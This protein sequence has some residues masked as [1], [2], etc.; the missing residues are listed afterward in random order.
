MPTLLHKEHGYE[1]GHGC[2]CGHEYEYESRRPQRV[3]EGL[4]VA[5]PACGGEWG[6]ERGVGVARARGAALRRIKVSQG[7]RRDSWRG[8]M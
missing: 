2:G 5:I 1:Y 4:Y 7:A 6:G 8:R 3:L